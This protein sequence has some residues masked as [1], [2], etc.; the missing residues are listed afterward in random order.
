MLGR[1]QWQWHNILHNGFLETPI[2]KS[3]DSLETPTPG[4]PTI[5]AAVNPTR[6]TGPSDLLRAVLL[7]E[8]NTL[9][10]RI[11]SGLSKAAYGEWPK[12]Q[13]VN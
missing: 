3:K 7:Q 13:S 2:T 12:A 9:A 5:N 6:S 1:R 8:N 4:L 10:R 11:W